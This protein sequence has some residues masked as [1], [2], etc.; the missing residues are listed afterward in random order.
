MNLLPK[1]LETFMTD[2]REV[3]GEVVEA[4]HLYAIHATSCQTCSDP[5]HEVCAEGLKLLQDFQAALNATL[6]RRTDA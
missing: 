4:A 1:I 2:A 5:S 6:S 3:K